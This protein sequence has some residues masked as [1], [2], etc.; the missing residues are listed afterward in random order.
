MI[1]RATACGL[2]NMSQ[3]SINGLFYFEDF[4]VRS[5]TLVLDDC[6]LADPYKLREIMNNL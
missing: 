5:A 2:P 6:I 3:D 1:L 4:I